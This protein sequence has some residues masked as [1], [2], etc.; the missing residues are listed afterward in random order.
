MEPAHRQSQ[1]AGKLFWH[2]NSG[3]RKNGGQGVQA[4]GTWP[5]FGHCHSA[6]NPRHVFWFLLAC[7][8]RNSPFGAKPG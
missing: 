5:P 2:F 4:L 8:K 1:D 7:T 3:P 6:P